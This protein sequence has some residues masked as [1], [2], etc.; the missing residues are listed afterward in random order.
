MS[1][2]H[3]NVH[4]SMGL[5]WLLDLP[6]DMNKSCPECYSLKAILAASITLKKTTYLADRTES[7]S[8]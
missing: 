5:L 7:A 6:S 1:T 3:Q 2:E 4:E 8:R